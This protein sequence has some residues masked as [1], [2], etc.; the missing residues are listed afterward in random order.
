LAGCA[1]AERIRQAI[2]DAEVSSGDKQFKV[3]ASVGVAA[4]IGADDPT[5][6]IR[7][8][9]EAL[10]SAKQSGR[11][12][13][14]WHNGKEILTLG[15]HG[16]PPAAEYPAP[17]EA[18]RAKPTSFTAL[19]RELT[20]HVCDSR[21]SNSPLSLVCVRVEALH[22]FGY[23]GETI[24]GDCILPAVVRLIREKLLA[25]DILVPLGA[26]E[27]ILVLPGRPQRVA[28]QLIE[29]SMDSHAGQE[30]QRMHNFRLR[31]EACEILPHEKAEE[32][33]VHAREGVLVATSA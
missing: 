7:R 1:V 5:R 17:R 31:Y 21:R 18:Q 8:A 24:N 10:F 6:M 23:P 11:N 26:A 3:T 33:L 16:L 28:V 29:D 27:L 20:R 32:L 4:A 22:T 14:R 2:E 25:T 15:S 12:C 30:M 13:I 19:N 9:D